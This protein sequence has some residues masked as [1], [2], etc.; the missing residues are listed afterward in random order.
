MDKAIP[1]TLAG[2]YQVVEHLG[3]GGFRQTFLARDA[4]LPG[5]SLCVVKQLKPRANDPETLLIA[6]RL[7]DRE[8]ETLYQLG[9]Q[10]ACM[11]KFQ[12]LH[13]LLDTLIRGASC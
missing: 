13:N 7:F 5:S 1:S 6:K 9:D 3:G 4:H 10:I 2:H 12:S 8:A 11:V